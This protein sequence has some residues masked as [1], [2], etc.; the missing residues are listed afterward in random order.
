MALVL[1]GSAACDDDGDGGSSSTSSGTGGSSTSSTGTGGSTSGTGGSTSSGCAGAPTCTPP[2]PAHPGEG[3]SSPGVVQGTIEST[4]G[5]AAADIPAEVCGTNLCKQLEVNGQG[6]FNEDYLQ[7][8]NLSDARFL[9]G[10]GKD[11]VL[12]GTDL[13]SLPDS[14]FGTISAVPM[15]P[16]SEGV[17]FADGDITQ[18]G[19][20]LS[21]APCTTVDFTIEWDVSQQVFRAVM[22]SPSDGTFPG[23]E[24]SLDFEVMVALAP[25]PAEICPAA[26]L[27]IP[28]DAAWAANAEVEFML[29]GTRIYNHYSQYGE[30]SVVSEG[31]VSGDG[32]TVTTNDG[33]GIP[34]LGLY[35]VRLK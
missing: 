34:D 13:P 23:I 6:I 33:E 3:D 17:A 31:T 5:G 29:Y 25:M 22:F 10:K 1:A 14:D 4:Q 26:K 15:P 2:Q 24:A 28:N 30:W 35:G 7:A 18:N 16:F 27:T 11:W 12:M 32:V 20:T 21:L 8:D 19:V 9:Y